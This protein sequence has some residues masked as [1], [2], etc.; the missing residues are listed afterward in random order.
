MHNKSITQK[1]EDGE[2]EIFVETGVTNKKQKFMTLDSLIIQFRRLSSKLNQITP[3]KLGKLL[4][5]VM[6]DGEF[7]IA[8]GRILED[9]GSLL[10]TAKSIEES[11]RQEIIEKFKEAEKTSIG[12]IKEGNRV[13]K[14]MLKSKILRED[15]EERML[16]VTDERV[17]RNVIDLARGSKTVVDFKNSSQTIGGSLD[18]PKD[19][20]GSQRISYQNCRIVT[21]AGKNDFDIEVDVESENKNPKKSIRVSCDKS[22]SLNVLMHLAGSVSARFDCEVRAIEEIK[23]KKLKLMVINLPEPMQILSAVE[24]NVS[25]LKKTYQSGFDFK[26]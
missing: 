22:S 1:I 20:A 14:D 5:I 9:Q 4:P 12:S 6:I 11:A 15:L 18:I 16:D 26:Q 17:A 23:S 24:S 10:E 19:V 25:D 3:S 7:S 21:F 2:F 13:A 8:A